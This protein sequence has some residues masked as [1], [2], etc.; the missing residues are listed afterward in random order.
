MLP[1]HV[2]HPWVGA[3]VVLVVVD[4]SNIRIILRT[5]SRTKSQ[6]TDVDHHGGVVLGMCPM[7]VR[8]HP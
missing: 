1:R 5:M 2:V 8:K 4:N 7:P 3:V 6:H